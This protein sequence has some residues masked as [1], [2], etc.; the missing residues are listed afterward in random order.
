MFFSSN[1]A[2][3][4]EGKRSTPSAPEKTPD[5]RYRCTKH[6]GI[7]TRSLLLCEARYMY[8]TYIVNLLY[9]VLYSVIQHR[10]WFTCKFNSIGDG[11][12]SN[13]ISGHA[14][15]PNHFCSH[16]GVEPGLCWAAVCQSRGAPL[17][18]DPSTNVDSTKVPEALRM[19]TEVLGNTWRESQSGEREL[20]AFCAA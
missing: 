5:F 2:L 18:R 10:P 11:R 9:N 4:L 20:L 6:Q 1:I 8:S 7:D 19:I 16:S 13:F 17:Q 12:I 14:S 15:T 3:R